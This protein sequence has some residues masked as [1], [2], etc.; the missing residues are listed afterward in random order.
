MVILKQLLKRRLHW[1]DLDKDIFNEDVVRTKVWFGIF[2][3]V[4]SADVKHTLPANKGK[5]K[6]GF[7][8]GE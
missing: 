8:D 7:I 6:I 3:F 4:N 5:N 2:K 1:V